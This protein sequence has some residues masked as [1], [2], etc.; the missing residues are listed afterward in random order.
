MIVCLNM[1]VYHACALRWGVTH[2][3]NYLYWALL[4]LSKD[5]HFRSMERS[6]RRHSLEVACS[7]KTDMWFGIHFVEHV[8]KLKILIFVL[9]KSNVITL[10]ILYIVDVLVSIDAGAQEA[11]ILLAFGPCVVI[12]DYCDRFCTFA[13]AL[14]IKKTLPDFRKWCRVTRHP[15][16]FR[17]L[18]GY[19]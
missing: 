2:I 4:T 13:R 19:Q 3:G 11:I 5:H 8:L 16:V 9:V 6:G 18:T 15:R 14:H 17:G 7:K 12:V 10:E 1:I